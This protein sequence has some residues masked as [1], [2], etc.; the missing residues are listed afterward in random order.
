MNILG[1]HVLFW[2][3][4]GVEVSRFETVL[5][6]IR[7]IREECD[8][9]PLTKASAAEQRRERVQDA[10]RRIIYHPVPY[11]R[12]LE[13][14]LPLKRTWWLWL[15]YGL[16]LLSV[17]ALIWLS[18]VTDWSGHYASYVYSYQLPVAPRFL[19]EDLALTRAK[20][21][22]GTVIDDAS[23]WKPVALSRTASLSPDGIRDTYL[24][25]DRGTNWNQGVLLFESTRKTNESWL[26]T[27]VLNGDQ[28]ECTVSRKR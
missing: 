21:S 18:A 10:R 13:W 15:A 24:M 4:P 22:L 11:D 14:R 8:W 23:N 3:K 27:L 28:L 19:S 1:R 12:S 6:R 26:V 2:R 5:P 20:E 7:A 9:H 25:R 16:A 17:V